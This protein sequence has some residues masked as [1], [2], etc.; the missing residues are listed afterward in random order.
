MFY[1]GVSFLPKGQCFS[2]NL[3]QLEA[4]NRGE[5]V[6]ALR[7]SSMPIGNSTAVEIHIPV[8]GSALSMMAL[9]AMVV[10]T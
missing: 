5:S 8:V 2:K 1:F 10:M 3:R 9:R 6:V 4:S 7:V